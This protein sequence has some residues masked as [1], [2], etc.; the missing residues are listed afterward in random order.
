MPCGMLV[1]HHWGEQNRKSQWVDFC[2]QCEQ[3]TLNCAYRVPQWKSLMN[4]ALLRKGQ[5]NSPKPVLKKMACWLTTWLHGPSPNTSYFTMLENGHQE[6]REG[7][8]KLTGF[9]LKQ[10]MGE[11]V[12]STTK[13]RSCSFFPSKQ[14]FPCFYGQDVTGTRKCCCYST[15]P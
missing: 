7:E 6:T 8:K 13:F 2:G 1:G 15:F 9:V 14:L 10:Q 12:D 4:P 5:E 11:C 3:K